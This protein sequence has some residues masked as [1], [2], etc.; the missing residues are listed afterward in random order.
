MTNWTQDQLDRIDTNDEVRISTRRKD[1]SLR[2]PVIVWAVVVDEAVYVRAV[3]GRESPW[4]RGTQTMQLGV[5]ETGPLQQEIAFRDASAEMNDAIDAAYRQKYARYA[6][7]IV[8]STVTPQART[9]TL[10]LIP[11][12]E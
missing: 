7:S 5:V 2:D 9:A 3:R 8:N 6:A 4:F 1:G 11:G 12:D 10:R